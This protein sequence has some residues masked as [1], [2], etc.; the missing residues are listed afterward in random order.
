[1]LKHLRQE[2]CRGLEFTLRD[3]RSAQRFARVDAA[4]LPRKSALQATMGAVRA[5]TWERINRRLLS[6]ARDAGVETGERVRIDSTVTATHILEPA[7]SRLLYDGVRVLTRLLD[8]ARERLRA[9]AVAF[10]DH[11][12][13]VKRRALEIQ[14]QRGAQ[15]RAKTYRK[16][17]RLVSRTL[18][19]VEHALPAVAVT[20]APWTG[21]W[22]E[23]VLACRDLLERVVDQTRRRVFGG[24][25]VPAQEKVVS[26]FEPH[27]DI[28]VKGGR[29]THYGHKV[30]FATGR[31]G[32]ALDVVVED[33]NPA[34]SARCLPMLARHVEHYG[35][36]P[37]HAAFDGGYASREN[38]KQ[39]KA[40]GVTHA[41]FH[42]KRG[43]KVAD[44]TPSAWLWLSRWNGGSISWRRGRP[45]VA[46]E[47]SS[48]CSMRIAPTR[49]NLRSS[50]SIWR[51]LEVKAISRL[52]IGLLLL[53]D[54][55]SPARRRRARAAL[56]RPPP[57]APQGLP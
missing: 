23:K 49:R 14:S 24:E 8:A 57:G 7:D 20:N 44:M 9:E 31:S 4:R 1:M 38:L 43:M 15:R 48:F 33:G 18:G 6:V 17:L 26:L 47:H 2:T 5:T 50:P 46:V 22:K 42:K 55:S 11:R 27:T 45:A 25:T 3:S 16:L 53:V 19:Y 52:S 21:R 35:A 51:L 41:V 29:G 28:V 54:E 56:S 10:H 32:L 40:L 39:A 34:D 12:R 36:A 30:N 13:A 37:T